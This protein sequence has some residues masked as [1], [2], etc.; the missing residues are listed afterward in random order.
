MNEKP[1][2]GTRKKHFYYTG[3]R[4]LCSEVG[5]GLWLGCNYGQLV[6]SGP[7][8]SPNSGWAG[9]LMVGIGRLG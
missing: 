9:W 7:F 4:S 8:L 1:N 3:M 2:F 5:Y 6:V